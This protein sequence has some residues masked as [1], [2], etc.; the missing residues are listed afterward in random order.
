MLKIKITKQYRKD[1]KKARSQQ[2]N[3]NRLKEVIR[4]IA[5]QEALPENLNDH[6]L[7]GKLKDQRDCHIEP[8]FILIYE[9]DDD[10]LILVRLGTH[11]ELFR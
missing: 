6:H 2:R 9:I 5:N 7:S 11:S 10:T 3:L 1:H 8:D 4:K